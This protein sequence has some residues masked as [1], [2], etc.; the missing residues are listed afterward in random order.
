MRQN[1]ISKSVI[2]KN[3]LGSYHQQEYSP[4][5]QKMMSKAVNRIYKKRTI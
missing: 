4:S 1:D 2:V 5:F 3:A